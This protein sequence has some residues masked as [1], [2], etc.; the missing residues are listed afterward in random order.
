MEPGA[1]EN[2][3][4]LTPAGPLTCTKKESTP[5]TATLKPTA[6]EPDPRLL[7]QPT[8]PALREH[9]R[10]TTAWRAYAALAALYAAVFGLPLGSTAAAYLSLG[11]LPT[12]QAPRAETFAAAA[13][14]QW[15]LHALL[16]AIA[17]LGAWWILRRRGMSMATGLGLAPAWTTTQDRAQRRRW[18]S[19]GRR[20]FFLTVAAYG[21]WMVLRALLASLAPG[22][23]AG[24]EVNSPADAV[25]M[26]AMI[27]PVHITTAL[28]EEVVV[29]GVLVVVLAAAQRPAWEVYTVAVAAKLLYHAYYGLPVL[30]MIPAVLI[31]VWLYRR[32]GRLMPIIA[33]H[34]AYN[35]GLSALV[36]TAS[37]AP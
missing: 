5:V 25:W 7:P 23:A 34:A 35:L 9:P 8:D 21:S 30:G 14:P 2:P 12:V 4:T 10:P 24:F 19:Q 1:F 6:P 11:Q 20:V 3:R 16:V 22:T 26:V 36:L 28:I 29:V 18:R 31:T 27:G 15:G 17:L 37:L 13:L 33:A 32:T